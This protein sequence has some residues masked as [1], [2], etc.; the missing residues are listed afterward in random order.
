M[1]MGVRVKTG[2]GTEVE[3]YQAVRSATVRERT[4]KMRES[5]VDYLLRNNRQ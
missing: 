2:I 1:K 4:G 3:T 5:G